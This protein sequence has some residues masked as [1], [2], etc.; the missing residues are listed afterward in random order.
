MI[1]VY[2]ELYKE[3]QPQVPINDDGNDDNSDDECFERE[4]ENGSVQNSSSRSFTRR[5]TRDRAPSVF[6]SYVYNGMIFRIYNLF[7]VG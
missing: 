6:F 1:F 7:D 4:I 3:P 5:L 2:R